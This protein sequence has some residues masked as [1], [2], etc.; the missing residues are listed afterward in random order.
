M[1]AMIESNCL[2]PIISGASA[3]SI[4]AGL[5]AVHTDEELM[6]F[7]LTDDAAVRYS[8]IVWLPPFRQQLYNS[9]TST[10]AR[11]VSPHNC[12]KCRSV[13]SLNSILVCC[14]DHYS[15]I[16]VLVNHKC[17]CMFNVVVHAQIEPIQ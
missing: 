11:G 3:G 2:P 14:A 15:R 8:P 16:A 9:C 13:Y 1:R 7:V 17:E 5:M 12:H 10:F 6:R 4:V